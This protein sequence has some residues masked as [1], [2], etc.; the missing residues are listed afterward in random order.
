MIAKYTLMQYTSMLYT[1][2]SFIKWALG[3]SA[4]WVVKIILG[5]IIHALACLAPKLYNR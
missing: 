2:P 4:D 5:Q 3:T 1:W